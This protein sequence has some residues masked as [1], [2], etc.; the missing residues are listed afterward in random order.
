MMYRDK[1]KTRVPPYQLRFSDGYEPDRIYWDVDENN[2]TPETLSHNFQQHTL[3]H[4]QVQTLS[5]SYCSFQIELRLHFIYLIVSSS[6][7]A[8]I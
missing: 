4:T 8:K 6:L 3:Q 2:S 1:W 5:L 7:N